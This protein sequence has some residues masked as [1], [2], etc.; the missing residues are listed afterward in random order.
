MT[1]FYSHRKNKHTENT[2]NRISGA[3]TKYRRRRWRA[4][5][6]KAT[7]RRCQQIGGGGD[8]VFRR[9][10]SFMRTVIQTQVHTTKSHTCKHTY[11]C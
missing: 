8:D 10:D 11:T 6:Q 2:Q 1:L 9:S 7:A 4:D 3:P 5:Q